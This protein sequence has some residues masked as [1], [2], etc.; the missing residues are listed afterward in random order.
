M[1]NEKCA[2]KPS[3]MKVEDALTN[4]LHLLSVSCVKLHHGPSAN[5]IR[6][7]AGTRRAFFVTN[8][9]NPHPGSEQKLAQK[10]CI[11]KMKVRWAPLGS[12]YPAGLLPLRD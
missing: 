3:Q 4:A 9:D 5:L 1:L 7:K 11:A 6:T 8:Q 12:A 10:A 2:P